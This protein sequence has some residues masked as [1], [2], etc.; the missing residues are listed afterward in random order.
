MNVITLGTFDLF[1][2]GHVQL[3]KR[4]REIAGADGKVVVALNSDK[5]VEAFKKKTPVVA[6]RERR[7]VVEACR[8]VDRVTYNDQDGL[9]VT[10]A[11]ETIEG[12]AADAIVVGSDW[13]DRDYLGQ[14]GITQEWL[15]KRGI[16][17][18][19]VPYT[20]GISSTAIRG[21]MAPTLHTPPTVHVVSVE[22]AED[23]GVEPGVFLR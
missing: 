13:R 23:F 17:V 7:L 5:F 11:A 21:R 2:S 20:Q 4:C 14:L 18:I 12:A 10:S 22:D 15:D 19:Y 8:Y 9:E 1:H 16:Y 3:L 6:F